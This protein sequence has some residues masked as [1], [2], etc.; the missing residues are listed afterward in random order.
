MN[1]DFLQSQEYELLRG[2][3]DTAI[4][5]HQS[6]KE[7]ELTSILKTLVDSGYITQDQIENLVKDLSQELYNALM[8]EMLSAYN[9]EDIENLIQAHQS[10][11]NEIQMTELY[12]RLYAERKD[13]DLELYAVEIIEGFVEQ[14]I[15][16]FKIAQQTVEDVKDLTDDEATIVSDL[17]DQGLVDEAEKRLTEFNNKQIQTQQP[18]D[19]SDTSNIN[20]DELQMLYQMLKNNYVEESKKILARL[21]Q[22]D[23]KE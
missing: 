5:N 14:L 21:L 18:Q 15:I 7:Q 6:Q 3:I 23:S 11:L 19:S 1:N 9:K 8:R 20:K 17:I 22:K 2:S 12:L 13:K 10:G 16:Q 4:K